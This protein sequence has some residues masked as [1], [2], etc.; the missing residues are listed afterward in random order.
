MPKSKHRRTPGGKAV[1]HPGRARKINRAG[2]LRDERERFLDRRRRVVPHRHVERLGRDVLFGAVRDRPFHS[3][4]DRFDDGR[5][6]ERG[7]GG[8]AQRLGEQLGLFGDD[9]EPE[10]LDGNQAVAGRLICAENGT[11]SANTNLMQHPEGAEC[12]RRRESL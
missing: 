11:K 8:P 9:V 3:R 12:W 1:A 4:R 6:K 5:V 10:D 2:Q 7:F